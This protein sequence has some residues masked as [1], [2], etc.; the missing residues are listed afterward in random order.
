MRF[1]VDDRRDGVGR[2]SV[3]PNEVMSLNKPISLFAASKNQG[4]ADS[5]WSSLFRGEVQ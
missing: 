5:P 4:R 3:T 2:S 1:Q